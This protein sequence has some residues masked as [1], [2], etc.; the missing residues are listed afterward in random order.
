MSKEVICSK[1]KDSI[2]TILKGLNILNNKDYS[3][4]NMATSNEKFFTNF[5]LCITI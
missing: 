4:L 3:C 5:L 2:K 1:I